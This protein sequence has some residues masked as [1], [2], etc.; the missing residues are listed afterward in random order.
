MVIFNSDAALERAF[1]QI[2]GALEKS[3]RTALQLCF[4]AIG[5]TPQNTSTLYIKEDSAPQWSDPVAT[6]PIDDARELLNEKIC[7]LLED[8]SNDWNFLQGIMMES[9]REKLLNAVSKGW[10]AP[11]HG[12]GSGLITQLEARLACPK[13]GLR[14]FA[15]YDSDR[16]HPDEL[17]EGWDAKCL[18]GAKATCQAYYWEKV[19]KDKMP[20][21]YWMLKRRFIESYMP[22]DQLKDYCS[23]NFGRGL[24]D[25][26]VQIFFTELSDH[27]RWYYNMKEG[28]SGDARRVDAERN[29]SL[30]SDLGEDI[31]EALNSGFGRSLATHYAKHQDVVFRWD[32]SAIEE[33]LN[34][35]PNLMRLI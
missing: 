12:G 4:R 18:S 17:Q 33:A 19:T 2:G 16:L 9:E 11:V 14:T 29:R 5:T 20:L 28:L 1:S 10:A 7:I 35:L 32:D 13:E 27:Q 24:S 3:Y 8:S 15:I 25:E 31:R 21:R 23:S 26:V 30:Y 22:E 34:A 6:L